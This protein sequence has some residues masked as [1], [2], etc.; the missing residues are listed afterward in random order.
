MLQCETVFACLTILMEHWTCNRQTHKQKQG[1]CIYYANIALS[2]KIN[3]TQS[4]EEILW[5]IYV[6]GATYVETAR[7]QIIKYETMLMS[8]SFKN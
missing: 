5:Y 8:A 1:Y 6:L 7:K 2:D 3:F 4:E